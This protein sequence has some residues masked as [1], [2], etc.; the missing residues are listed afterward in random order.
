MAPPRWTIADADVLRALE[1]QFAGAKRHQ[2]LLQLLPQLDA[3]DVSRIF[4]AKFAPQVRDVI[5]RHPTWR[6]EHPAVARSFEERTAA[7]S[8]ES[9]SDGEQVSAY[10]AKRLQRMRENQQ[11][12]AALGIQKLAPKRAYRKRVADPEEGEERKT[13]RRSRRI[14]EA[15]KISGASRPL[16][17]E[18]QEALLG[19]PLQGTRRSQRLRGTSTTYHDVDVP[20]VDLSVDAVDAAPERPEEDPKQPAVG[21]K[22]QR[23][24]SQ[25]LAIDLASF[26]SRWL[27][28][29]IW[30]KGKHTIM[31]GACPSHT[32]LFSKMS[33]V[34]AWRNA[35]L[36]FVNVQG[37][38][39]YD[40]VF[41]QVERPKTSTSS[42][43]D[44]SDSTSAVYFQWFAQQR[45]HLESP[46]IKRLLRAQKGDASLRIEDASYYLEELEKQQ[47]E[48]EA[49]SA[50]E[51]VLLFI[52]HVDGPYIY[53]GRLGYLG[54]RSGSSPLEF[55]WQL[56]DV[57]ALAWDKIQ[58]LVE[59]SSERVDGAAVVEE[60]E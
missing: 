10:E 45:Q 56:L 43:D 27:G 34:Q 23:L 15:A 38:S 16:T 11:V 2:R 3:L 52:R 49:T 40:N 39:M 18:E 19:I 1:L 47:Q 44:T 8:R 24:S 55:R 22:R 48:E 20:V 33:G 32:P 59:S 42:S 13:L 31:Q 9:G 7:D 4:S 17:R 12:L 5:D 26:H 36:L 50:P 37:E 58:T 6:A 14:S 35:V 46:V 30:P 54:F 51:P 25:Q 57:A 28:N 60:R 41:R 21:V 29:Q 53:C